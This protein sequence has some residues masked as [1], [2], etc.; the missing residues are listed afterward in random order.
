MS[1]QIAVT[2]RSPPGWIGIRASIAAL[3]SMPTTVEPGDRHRRG[4]PT[5][6]DPEFEHPAAGA[7]EP[8]HA[9][10]RR[11]DVGHVGVPLVVHVG[12]AVAV[13]RRVVAVHRSQATDGP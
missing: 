12:E 4:E 13:A 6:T 7:G 2:I 1:P 10:H 11:R 5:G 3:E 8:D 9:P